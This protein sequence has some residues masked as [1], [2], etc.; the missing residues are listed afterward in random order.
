MKNSRRRHRLQFAESLEQR[1]LLSYSVS[2]NSAVIMNTSLGEVAIS[3]DSNSPITT[4]NFLAYVN[5][6]LYNGTVFHRIA[7]DNDTQLNDTTET[8]S[9]VQGGGYTV[10]GTTFNPIT[11]DAPITNEEPTTGNANSAGTIS[12]ARTSSPDSATSQFFFNVTDNSSI[13]DGNGSAENSGYAVFGNVIRG[14]GVVDTIDNLNPETVGN[15]SNVP[16]INTTNSSQ[17]PFVTITTATEEDTLTA[18]LGP[19]AAD[20]TK[21]V[22]FFDPT[23]KSKVTISMTADATL[24]FT[25]TSLSA[26]SKGS[27][28][29]ISG[30][31]VQLQEINS[32]DSTAKSTLTVKGTA[33][34][35][36]D[37]NITG[38]VKSISGSAANLT[39]DISI[40]GGVGSIKLKSTTAAGV[41]A[42][43]T[44]S[45]SGAAATAI[46]VGSLSDITI[47]DGGSIASLT[48]KSYVV[49]DGTARAV[50]ASGP[51][52]KVTISGEMDAGVNGGSVGTYRAGEVRS[53]I[54]G[55]STVGSVTALSLN[56]SEIYA[57]GAY[58]ASTLGVGKVTI[59]GVMNN[60]EIVALGNIGSVKASSMSGSV[61]VAGYDNSDTA[62]DSF[63]TPLGSD[64]TIQ[65][66]TLKT[67][68]GTATS[69]SDSEI[70]AGVINSLVLG[71]IA[72]SLAAS[73]SITV[74]GIQATDLKS[75]IATTDQNQS[76][77]LTNITTQDQLNAAV[78]TQKVNLGSFT[79]SIITTSDIGVSA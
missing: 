19:N 74:M 17:S 18:T 10:S 49:N 68:K 44:N 21:S 25:G 71:R 2:H 16:E 35:L 50:D 73:P 9:I 37:I 69:F 24:T 51:I 59:S 26:V 75:L 53:Y 15:F 78:S 6:G 54:A 14:M 30:T 52:S 79:F 66:V 72:T 5:A 46:N 67:P 28:L 62:Q 39:G 76:L 4:A 40:T 27:N 57:G 65:S 48:A 47:Q 70:S 36:G 63:E 41:I 8:Y 1:T 45:V 38:S 32:T 29:L 33:T 23:S 56:D 22:T 55:Q 31:N 60:S 43:D 20:G 13:F 11:T 12:M 77:K 7:V 61:I 58:S 34:N 64:A 3:L 42:L